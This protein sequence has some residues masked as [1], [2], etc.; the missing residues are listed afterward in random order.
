[1]LSDLATRWIAEAE[2]LAAWGDER[3]ATLLRRCIRELQAEERARDDETLTVGQACALSGYS[4]DHLRALI[5]S[6]TIPNR[7]R[8]GS[9]RIARRDLPMKPGARAS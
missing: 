2:T 4:A 1:M 9:P 5:A 8:K 3:G 6:G 7:G